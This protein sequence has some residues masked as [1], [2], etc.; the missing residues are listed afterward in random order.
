GL[1]NSK[2]P[3]PEIED[4][5][6]KAADM[7]QITPYL[8]RRPKALSGGQRQRVAIGRAIVRDPKAFLFDEPLSNL[9]AELRVT[10]RKELAALHQS[11]GGT[12]IYVTHDQ[13]EAMTLADKIVVLQGGVV[14]QAGKPLELYN[15]PQN[16]FVAGFIGS[17]RMNLIEAK[18]EN[19]GL[20]V[21]SSH[22]SIPAVDGVQAGQSVTFG[23]RPEHL[24][25]ADEAS[26]DF[27]A[28]VDF[29]EQLGGETYL[30]C[31]AEGMPQ[32]TVHQLGQLP[33]A[34]GDVLHLRLDRAS[35][36]LFDDKGQVI[37]N[38]LAA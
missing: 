22:I 32:L 36:H 25:I 4:R 11:I 15:T 6:M 38:G 35:T 24:D 26:A 19:G 17:P 5:V 8:Q 1:E 31:S 37:A 13:T 9:D 34:S 12:M 14:E 18:T 23:I 7:L 33:V 16:V 27:T 10:M 20:T 28:K 2:M 30:Y 29:S 3:K 21:G